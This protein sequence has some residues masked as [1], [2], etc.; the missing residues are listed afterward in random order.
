MFRCHVSAR[1]ARFYFQEAHVAVGHVVRAAHRIVDGRTNLLTTSEHK[2]GYTSLHWHYVN[3]F[4][5]KKK[6][7]LQ[8][9]MISIISYVS[10]K[11]L[12]RVTVYT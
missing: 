2:T 10:N 1:S 8:N 9:V 3:M 6:T 5:G 4:A 7:L 11:R 12:V